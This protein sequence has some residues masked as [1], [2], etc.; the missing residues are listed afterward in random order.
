MFGKETHILV[1]DD[2]VNI[3]RVI[4]DNLT[5]LG[6]KKVATAS[7][8]NEAF[9]KLSFFVDSPTPIQLVLS[10]L[11]MPGP[12]GLDFLKKVRADEKF[13]DLP[14]ILITTESEKGAVIEAAVSG[15][16]G[17]V[18]KPFNIETLTK[19]L[20]DAWTKHHGGGE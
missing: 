5:R 4:V 8:A 14:F 9:G 7:E 12:S 10:D 20:Q 18:V 17:Y 15:V 2:S 1:V 3:R 6:F 16:S 19:R 11:N 13:K